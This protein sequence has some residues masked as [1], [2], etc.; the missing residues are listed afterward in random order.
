MSLAFI[1]STIIGT[2]SHEFG[3]FTVAK[4][5]GYSSTV[6]YGYTNWDDSKTRPFIDSVFSKYSKELEANLDFPRKK[7]F[8]L[9]QERQ[10]KD[11]FWITLGG[12]IQTMLTGTIGLLLLLTQ[13]RKILE[14]KSIK[15]YQWLCIFLSLFW[16]RQFA[17]LVTWTV[18][19]FINGEFSLDGDEVRLAL[20]LGLPKATLAVSSAIIGL[21]ILT[22]VIFKIIPI[23]KRIT[24][25]SA[26][27]FG[28][29]FGYLFWLVWVGPILM[30]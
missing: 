4:S 26:G 6:S 27:L 1:L 28:G 14:T 23:D 16:L 19:Y 24:F 15:L 17:N 5:L 9:I 21:A 30:P 2:V 7:E 29:I 25:I 12:P 10:R 3:H 18:G 11:A 22:F 8:D 13:R 20:S